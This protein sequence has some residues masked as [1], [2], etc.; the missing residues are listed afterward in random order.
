MFLIPLI[1]HGANV[2][3]VNDHDRSA[4]MFAA[5]DGHAE[6]VQD[7]VAASANVDLDD[8]DGMKDEEVLAAMREMDCRKRLI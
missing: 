5:M 7:L 3:M 4:L 6:I 8:V 1:K 2:D